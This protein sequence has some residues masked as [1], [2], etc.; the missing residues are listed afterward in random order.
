MFLYY[1]CDIIK[2]FG[3]ETSFIILDENPWI[4]NIYSPS[5]TENIKYKRKFKKSRMFFNAK[6]IYTLL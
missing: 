3:F 1:E 4:S 2:S 5:L 6:L